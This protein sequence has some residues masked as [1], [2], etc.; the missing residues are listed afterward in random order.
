MLFRSHWL[1]PARA[2]PGAETWLEAVTGETR[3]A[4]AVFR[5]YG[6]GKTLYL[7]FDESWRW[8]YKVGDLYHQKFWNQAAK[9]VME[10]PFAV[11]DKFVSLDSGAL[12]YEPGATAEIRTRILDAQGRAMPRAKAEAMVAVLAA[13]PAVPRLVQARLD[14]S[15]SG[16]H[17]SDE[18]ANVVIEF[19]NGLR[20]HVVSSYRGGDSPMWDAQIGRAHV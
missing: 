15:P 14:G 4:A 9:F 11:H 19:S 6:A 5:R 20:A 10:S 17:G 1:A 18:Q 13:A 7:A 2:L 12:N 3:S 8:R 16:R